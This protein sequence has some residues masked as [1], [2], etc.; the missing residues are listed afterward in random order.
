MSGLLVW[1]LGDDGGGAARNDIGRA[2]LGDNL[3]DEE[4]DDIGVESAVRSV[5]H[6]DGGG[7]GEGMSRFVGS[8]AA[9]Q[10]VEDI[11]DGEDSALEFD[12]IA[13]N[14]VRIARAVEFFMV[15][16]DEERNVC[17]SLRP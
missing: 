17:P 5:V 13:V 16:K 11:A 8:V 2:E 6:E 10:G 9:G 15:L 12:L 4:V 3:S 7:V 14:A 1:K